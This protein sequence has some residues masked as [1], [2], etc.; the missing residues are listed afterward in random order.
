MCDARVHRNHEIKAAD[1]GG[2]LDEVG[3]LSGQI[4][5]V[6]PLP[7]S[8]LVVRMRVLLQADKGRIGVEDARKR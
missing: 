5:D 7:Q 2:R 6:A 8:R 3:E 4:D 1:Q